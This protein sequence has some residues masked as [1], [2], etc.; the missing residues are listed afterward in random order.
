MFIHCRG[1]HVT[2]VCC[3]A[4]KGPLVHAIP[5]WPPIQRLTCLKSRTWNCVHVYCEYMLLTRATKHTKTNQTFCRLMFVLTNSTRT[6][7]IANRRGWLIH[8]KERQNVPI[9]RSTNHHY[10]PR[11]QSGY[12]S[13]NLVQQSKI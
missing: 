5:R 10:W 2:S 9:V 13:T 4:Y 6:S 7:N 12:I 11:K 1:T 3:T 8:I